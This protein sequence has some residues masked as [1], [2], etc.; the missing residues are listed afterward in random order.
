MKI[1]LSLSTLGSVPFS[2]CAWKP[3][4]VMSHSARYWFPHMTPSCSL[5]LLSMEEVQ[6]KHQFLRGRSLKTGFNRINIFGARLLNRCLRLKNKIY[7]YTS[8]WGT[9]KKNNPKHYI[10]TAIHFLQHGQSRNDS[11]FPNMQLKMRCMKT[12]FWAWKLWRVFNLI[13]GVG[14][15]VNA[16]VGRRKTYVLS[17]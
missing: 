9:F 17:L 6:T 13:I 12:H 2:Q 10:T 1:H 5:P 3:P 11:R 15:T 14:P 4:M 7:H 8:Q 16:G